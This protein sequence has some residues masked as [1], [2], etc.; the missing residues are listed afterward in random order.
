M[1]L[2]TEYADQRPPESMLE[3]AFADAVDGASTD[4]ANA[5]VLDAAHELF[6]RQGIQR[7]TMDDV[8][9][10]A[11]VVPNHRLPTVRLQGRARRAGGAAGVP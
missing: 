2:M 7:T 11:G 3:R 10:R 5:S 4:A 9:R 6:C 1:S 8:A